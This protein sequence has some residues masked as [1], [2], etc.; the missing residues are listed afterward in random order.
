MA[1]QPPPPSHPP[2]RFGTYGG[3]GGAF[4]RSQAGQAGLVTVTATHPTLGHATVRIRVA[5]G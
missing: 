1:N 5:R 3:V 2:S 4:V